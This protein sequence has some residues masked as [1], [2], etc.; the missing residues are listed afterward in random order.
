L[1]E[2]VE[3]EKIVNVHKTRFGSCDLAGGYF[4]EYVGVRSSWN[5][6]KLMGS[7]KKHTN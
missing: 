5:L 2:N 7:M 6:L 3:A 4:L 1:V